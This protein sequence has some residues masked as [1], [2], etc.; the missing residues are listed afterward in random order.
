MCDM[1]VSPGDTTLVASV[2]PDKVR[3]GHD[4]GWL[5]SCYL[6]Q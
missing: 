4:E 3:V 6:D 2:T 1:G 5:R